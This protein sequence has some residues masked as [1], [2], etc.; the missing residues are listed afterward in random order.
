[1]LVVYWSDCTICSVA[2]EEFHG[3]GQQCVDHDHNIFYQFSVDKQPT[4]GM[5]ES[6][7]HEQQSDSDY[8][9]SQLESSESSEME[10][11]FTNLEASENNRPTLNSLSG[12][13]K[14]K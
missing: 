3:V 11:E 13:L 1:M 6:S 2:V 9:S 14:G 12:D 5:E 10:D 4:M 8:S 7:D